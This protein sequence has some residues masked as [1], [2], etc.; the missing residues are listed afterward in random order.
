M[1]MEEAIGL[2]DVVVTND[3]LFQWIEPG[4]RQSSVYD[5]LYINKE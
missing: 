2:E 1:N 5:T 4:H 3:N